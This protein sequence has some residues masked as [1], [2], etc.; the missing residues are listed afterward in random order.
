M[1]EPLPRAVANKK[2]AMKVRVVHISTSPLFLNFL[3]GLLLDLRERGFEP[4]VVCSPGE[5]LDRFVRET[6]VAGFGVEMPRR[7][8]P[9][10]DVVA[11]YR[12]VILLR[13]LRP[14]IVHAHTPKGGLLGTTAAWMCRVPVRIYHIHG[15]PYLTASGAKRLLLRWSEKVACRLAHRVLCVGESMRRIAV[16]EKLCPPDRIKVLANGSGQGVDAERRFYLGRFTE[17][18]R[19]RLQAQLQIPLD[20]TVIGFVGRIVR[21]KGMQELAHAWQHLREDHPHLHLLLVGEYEEQDPVPAWV[22][23]TFASDSRVHIT[24]WVSDTA[25]YYAIM[26]LLVLPSYREGFPI[27]PLE[28]AAME[29][30]VVATRIPGNVDAVEDEVTGLLVPPRDAEALEQA[31]RCYL[32]CPA[33]RQQHGKAGRERVLRLFRQEVIWEALYNEYVALLQQ[34]GILPPEEH[35]R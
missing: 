21:D 1:G 35:A 17:T 24:G 33:L 8:T 9:L 11:L 4:S 18:E 3:R 28:A 15:L 26:H 32:D 29:L 6:G 30:P 22:E 27:T 34:R 25:P 23:Q 2:Q 13:R 19:E 14:H 20:A 16:E 10:R 31:I 7:I 5:L 12:L